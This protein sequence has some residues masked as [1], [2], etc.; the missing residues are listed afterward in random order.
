MIFEMADDTRIPT[1]LR[2]L[3]ILEILSKSDA[4]LTA[5]QINRDLGLPK[6]T[7]H[8]L[9]STLEEEGFITRQGTKKHY[10]PARRLREIGAGLL[11]HSHTHVARHQILMDVAQEVGETVNFVVPD[12]AGMSYVDRVETDWAFRIQL[13]IGTHVPFH[14]TASGKCFLSSLKPTERRRM[15]SSLM[16]EP[17]TDKTHTTPDSLLADLDQTAR[18][19]YAIDSEEFIEGM[20]ALAVPVQDASENFVAAVAFHGPKQRLSVDEA[21]SRRETL[22]SAAARLRDAVLG[23]SVL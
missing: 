13:P 23:S 2:M 4:P 18:R 5:T 11:H 14:C 7:I 1:N 12:R 16:L 20:V 21:I 10:Q 9:C 8:R 15:V 19:G 6:Q 17:L 22:F 3:L